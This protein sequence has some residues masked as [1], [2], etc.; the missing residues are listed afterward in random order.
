VPRIRAFLSHRFGWPDY[1]KP[2]VEKPLPENLHWTVTLGSVLV[3]LFIIQGLTG[4]FLAM[5][6]N[7][8]PDHAYQAVDYIMQEVFLGRLLRGIH[9]WGASAMVI[10]VVAHMMVS[11]FTGAFKPPREMT[12]IIGVCL[13]LFTLGFGFTGYLLPWDQKAYWATVVGTNIPRDIPLIG[14]F[15]TR[16]LLAGDSVSGLT[17]TRFYAI[18][19]LIFPVLAAVCI[20]MHIYLVRIHGISEHVSRSDMPS[21]PLQETSYHFFPEHLARAS[22][23]FA[24][25]FSVILLLAVFA[26]I[27]DEEVAGTIDPDYLPRPEWYYMWLFQLLTLFSGRTE[28]IGSLVIPIG[29][30]ILLFCLPFLSHSPYRSSAERPVATA[31][32]VACLV[33]IVYLSV[34]G[35]AGSR[36]YGEIIRIP[37]R[38]LA[39]SEITGLKIFVERDCAYCHHIMGGGGRRQGPDLSNVVAKDR[40]R[41][42]LVRFINNPQSVNSWSIMPKYDLT[43]EELHALADFILCLDFTRYAVKTV[44]RQAVVEGKI[45]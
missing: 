11:F 22:G 41:K 5:Y 25:V 13:F 37:D 28:I 14:K 42:W 34:M 26:D 24:V 16:I 2:F 15:V 38:K 12:W 32:G 31:I 6:Y 30:I 1:V 17:L 21:E 8:S 23:T 36:P 9:H 35:I 10:I 19:T 3:L 44:S 33:G 7:P 4:M 39:A 27:P 20:G 43:T 40:T 29:G 18:H 45:E